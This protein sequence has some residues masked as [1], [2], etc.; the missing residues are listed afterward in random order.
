M[1]YPHNSQLGVV[2]RLRLN[3]ERYNRWFLN[4]GGVMCQG[5]QFCIH[6]I[7]GR[8]Q[9]KGFVVLSCVMLS[10]SGCAGLDPSKLIPSAVSQFQTAIGSVTTM[11]TKLVA[12]W[13]SENRSLQYI[14]RKDYNCGDP[15][16]ALYK[17]LA[18]ENPTKLATEQ[19]VNKYWTQS[20]NY[21]TSY[22][23]LL[24]AISTRAQNDAATIKQIVSIGTTAA[25]YIPSMPS[26]AASALS[27]LGTV[28]TDVSNLY[29]IDQ[30]R[31]AAQNA[32][33]PLAT[34]VKYLKKYYPAFLGNEQ[35]LFD[36]WDECVNE[37]LLFIRDEPLGKVK[38]YNG[39][40]FA[41]ANGLDLDNAY[42]AYIAQ[43]ES[44]M[45][46]GAAKSINASLDQI[47]SQNAS[48]ANPNLSWSDFQTAVQSI[49]T[50]Y[51]DVSNAAAAVEKFG[52]PAKPIPAPKPINAQI[53][54]GNAIVI[55]WEN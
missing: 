49:N 8:C 37:K 16:T 20:L 26:G 15:R 46:N 38:G 40:Y 44:F 54:P 9:T 1:S 3:T 35:V 43:R 24:T 4:L 28:A 53:S 21:L 13:Q 22:I 39:V 17:K 32:Q 27:A 7:F 41:T 23:K 31:A 12:A 34:A 25:G 5:K 36:A 51:T 6:A 18:S 48:L 30:I 55:A 29:A 52:T 14:S 10:T 33:A 47:L 45:L 19:Q 11:E 42:V 50:L 2:D